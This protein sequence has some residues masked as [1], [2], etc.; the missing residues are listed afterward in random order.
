METQLTQEKKIFEE[1]SVIKAVATMAIPTIISQV[2]TVIYNLA[3]TWYV[4]LTNSATQVAAISLCLPVYNIMTALANLFGIGG[5]SV[6][7]RKLGKGEEKQAKKAYSLSLRG[8]ILI[9]LIYSILMLVFGKRFLLLIGADSKNIGYAMSYTIITIVIGGLSTIL[10]A[11]FAHLIRST[12]KSKV[13]SFGIT[14]GAILNMVLD[15][16]FMFVILPK[17]NEVIGAAVATAISNYISLLF[18]I[19]YVKRNKNSIFKWKIDKEKI[20]KDI[21]IDIVKCG[22]PSFL[23]LGAAQVSNFFLNGLLSEMGAS[24]AV[25]GMGVVRKI[26]SLA[27]SVNQGITQG[28]L[29]IV[30]YCFSQKKYKRMKSVIFLSTLFTV[31]FSLVCS[32]SAIIFSKELVRFF[33][34][35][36]VTIVYGARFLKI[37]SC[38]VAIYPLTFVIVAVFQAIGESVKPFILSLLHKGSI[39]IILFFVIKRIVGIDYVMWASPIM[40]IIALM[41]AIILFIR[42]I[43]TVKEEDIKNEVLLWD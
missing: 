16:L 11:V 17:G 39:D 25:A 32:I 7:A 34:D 19:I 6:I 21:L 23:L 10:S 3:D 18:F 12:G 38:S 8:A 9:S 26:D 13:A 27:Y 40:E 15:P 14:I 20:N 28:M 2:I 41:I 33:I 22:L 30:S 24:E 37:M 35:D 42:W 1:Y 36:E 5:A 29:P 31:L 4:G 43:L